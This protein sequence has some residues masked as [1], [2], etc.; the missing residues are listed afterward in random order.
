M[1]VTKEVKGCIYNLLIRLPDEDKQKQEQ[2]SLTLTADSFTKIIITTDDIP[3]H[4]TPNGIIMM[5]VYDYLLN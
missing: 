4:T 1:F 2:R 3:T 5:N